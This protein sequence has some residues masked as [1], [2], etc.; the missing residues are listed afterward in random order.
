MS[1]IIPPTDLSKF[2]QA[3][4][5]KRKREAAAKAETAFDADLVPEDGYERAPED[6]AMDKI[7]GDIKIADAYRRWCNKSPVDMS[8]KRTEGVKISCPKPDHRDSNPSAWL[9]T[10]KNVWFC[11]TCQEG[12]DV[13]DIAAFHFG[14]PN[15]K[16]GAA[17]HELRRKMAQSYGYTFI[18][19]PG[20]DKPIPVAPQP[21]P[22]P[23]E[24]E[25]A[26]VTAIHEEDPED[27]DP[28]IIFP[29]LEW[30]GLVQPGTFLDIYM[31]QT[32]IEDVP[33]EYHFW[34]ALLAIGLAI[35]KDCT[36]FDRTPVYGNLF[37]CLLGN[38]GDGKSR[39]LSHL[40]TLLRQALPHKWDDPNSKGAH[41]VGAPASAEVLIH[42]F[43]KPI[44][45]PTNP[46]ILTGYGSVRGLI[47][48]N[49]LSSLVG[50]TARQGN[51]MKPTLMEF[52]DM[53]PVITTSSMT[54]GKKEAVDPF[55]SAFTTTQ[56][57]SLKK[58]LQKDDADSGF[59]NRWVF[60]SG[61]PK[62]RIAIGGLQIDVTP[63]VEPLQQIQGWVGFGK[64]ITWDDDAAARFTEFFHDVIHPTQLRDDGG[65]LTRLD[66][67]YKK[68]ILLLTAN[69]KLT[70]VP[71]EIVDQVI[72]MFRY[73]TQSA[74]IPTEQ[75]GNTVQLEIQDAMLRHIRNA[76]G[77][78]LS[79]RELYL[80][81]KSKKFQPDLIHKM[82][83][84]LTDIGE[85]ETVVTN[86]GR[87]RPTVRYRYV[88]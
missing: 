67:L 63:A 36:L 55:G 43:S 39:S 87:G 60:A 34:N 10:E 38:T 44:Y 26:S 46:K 78:G 6:D 80:K 24:P 3:L 33:E 73:L 13:Y 32:H 9:N 50:R 35:G 7:I 27:D 70:T 18:K 52:Y 49:E 2:R 4:E 81:I 71:I 65:M 61:K 29:T 68:L 82:L 88:G 8:N 76:G 28:E 53:V 48:F 16:D 62:Q 12:G 58:L 1:D 47:E 69:S 59:L 54:G 40:R 72:S 84:I 45:D 22:A 23:E 41:I 25:S 15:Y 77:K 42:N 14:V 17:F 83:K 57:R 56:P 11:G 66:L 19:P 75:I 21:E 86:T 31:R 20:V 30:R 64:K 37:L 74:A 85:L 79:Y 51:V 5:E